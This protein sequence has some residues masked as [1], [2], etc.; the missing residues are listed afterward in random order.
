MTTSI[1][2]HDLSHRY[3]GVEAVSGISFEVAAGE[4]FGLLGPNGA[5]KTTI[6][7]SILGLITPDEGRIAIGG[8]DARD[9]LWAVRAITGAALQATGLQDKITPREALDLFAA[10]YPAPLRTDDLL[11]R[12]GLMEK[13]GARTETLSGGQK[14]RLALALAFVGAPRVLVLDEP[15]TGLDP[16]M[17]RDVQDHVLAMKDSGRAILLATHDMEEAVR[18]CD[19]VAVIARGR[20]AATGAPRQLMAEHGGNLDDVILHLTAP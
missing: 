9:D 5:G 15:T 2:V 20:I 6:L 8:I 4:I 13:A 7:E 14:Q 17:R 3:G 10:F 1:A 11:T 19:R 16:Q 12:F 18:L